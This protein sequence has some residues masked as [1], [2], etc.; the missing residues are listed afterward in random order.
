MTITNQARE[1]LKKALRTSFTLVEPYSA[2]YRGDFARYLVTLEKVAAIPQ[3]KTKRILDA[4]TGIALL[5]LALR[6]AGFVA[7][8]I[9]YYI[10]PETGNTMFGRAEIERLQS[11]WKRNGLTVYKC[12]WTSPLPPAFFASADIIVSDATIEHLK[13]PKIFLT[14]CRNALQHPGYLILSTPNAATLLKRIRFL[15]GRSPNWPVAEF[16]AAGEAFTGHW[17]EYTLAELRTLC[18]LSGFTVR[19]AENRDVLTPWKGAGGFRKNLRALISRLAFLV[20]SSRDMNFLV[21]E[22]SISHAP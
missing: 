5:P 7:D 15:F 10:F 4:G 13:D 9:D 8:G 18:E 14:N 20:P 22:T 21:C 17:R 6:I 1:E 12:D 11:V 16:F 3:A 19:K 2:Q